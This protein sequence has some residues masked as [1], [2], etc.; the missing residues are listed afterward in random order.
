MIKG[1]MIASHVDGIYGCEFIEAPLPPSYSNQDELPLQ[2]EFEISQIGTIVDNTIKTRYIFEINKGSNKNP[3]IDVNASM[4]RVDRRIPMDRM[5][6]T[7]DGPSDVPV[8]S[9]VKSNGGK[10]YAVFNP[11]SEAEFAQNDAL[12]HA[13]RIHAYGPADYREKSTT[14]KWLRMH[15]RSICDGI[16]AEC[17]ASLSENV[18]R[19]PRHLHDEDELD[20]TSACRVKSQ[21]ELF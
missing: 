9:V 2:M 1:S 19:A 18:S 13:G 3:T 7:A 8:F 20:E 21:K 4:D 5:I 6:Y 17:E 14:S 15:V 16:V 10:T 11:E 12:L